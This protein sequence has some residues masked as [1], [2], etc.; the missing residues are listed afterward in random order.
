MPL[1][2]PIPPVSPVPPP[3]DPVR[4]ILPERRV[5]VSLNLFRGLARYLR[6]QMILQRR[7][8]RKPRSLEKP[9]SPGGFD[10]LA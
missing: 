7:K 5:G 9:M 8:K 10:R 3:V 4:P 1:G 2:N 6:Y